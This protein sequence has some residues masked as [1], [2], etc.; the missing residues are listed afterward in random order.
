[1]QL[2][3]KNRIKQ[4][5]EEGL[6]YKKIASEMGISVNTVKSYCRNNNLTSSHILSKTFCKE[7][8]KEIKQKQKCKKRVF[9]SDECKRNWWNHHKIQVRKTILEEHICLCCNKP[10]M[11]YPGENRKYCSHDCYIKGRFGQDEHDA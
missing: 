2:D 11:A 3:E 1:M 8:G 9:C 4:L 5:R 10:F 7:C 6:G